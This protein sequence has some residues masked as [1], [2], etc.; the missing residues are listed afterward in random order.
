MTG[1][2]ARGAASLTSASLV[3]RICRVR[4]VCLAAVGAREAAVNEPGGGGQQT[5]GL[6]V[7]ELCRR[8]AR[9][10]RRQQLGWQAWVHEEELAPLVHEFAAGGEDLLV[11]AA[12]H[13]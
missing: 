5:L 13:R 11:I 6:R 12:G 4:P 1:G 9:P 7:E 3:R 10:P 8:G 2:T